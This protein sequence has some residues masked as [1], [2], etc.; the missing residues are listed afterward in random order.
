V[1]VTLVRPISF[2]DA[3][4]DLSMDPLSRTGFNEACALSMRRDKRI[5]SK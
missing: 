5:F 1:R 3:P 4:T 2:C